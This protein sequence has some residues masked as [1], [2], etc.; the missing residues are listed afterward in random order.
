MPRARSKSSPSVS[1][2]PSAAPEPST[3]ADDAVAALGGLAI[4]QQHVFVRLLHDLRGPLNN[5]SMVVSLCEKFAAKQMQGGALPP[6]LHE[7][8]MTLRNEVGQLDLAAKGL[9]TLVEPVSEAVEAIHVGQMLGECV[10]LVRTSAMARRVAIDFQDRGETVSLVTSRRQLRC[11][12]VTVISSLIDQALPGTRIDIAMQSTGNEERDWVSC[13][14]TATATVVPGP[15]RRVIDA[16]VEVARRIVAGLGGELL[17]TAS[18]A[19]AQ[20]EFRLPRL[21]A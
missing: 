6:R 11:L 19:H 17:L 9:E 15:S 14:F 16:K 10:G 21:T 3:A 2:A 4:T 7:L 13:V 20:I 12:I 5:I 1:T 18:L 8:L